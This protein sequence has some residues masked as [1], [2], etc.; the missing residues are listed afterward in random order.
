[1]AISVQA[2]TKKLNLE[3]IDLSKLDETRGLYFGNKILTQAKTVELIGCIFYRCIVVGGGFEQPNSTFIDCTPVAEI[4]IKV[5]CEVHKHNLAFLGRLDLSDEDLQGANLQSVYLKG[6]NLIDAD[7][8]G[9]NL[10]GAQLKNLA[11]MGAKLQGANLEGANLQYANLQGAKLQGANLQGANLQDANLQVTYLQGANLEKA[12]IQRAILQRAN[13]ENSN[14]Q[15]ANLKRTVL[16]NANLNGANLNG[17]NLLGAEIDDVRGLDTAIFSKTIVDGWA[18]L[19]LP[20]NLA[21]NA[22]YIIKPNTNLQ[23]ADLKGVNL[24]GA[25]LQGANLQ[26]ANLQGAE[27]QGANLHLANLQGA[28]LQE[29]KL[30][31]AEL[32]GANL[33]GADL[34]GADLDGARYNKFTKGLTE[35][36]KVVMIETSE[37]DSEDDFD[38]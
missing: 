12:D 18:E 17:A 34:E 33:E 16:H 15:G 10:Q 36:Q 32:Q 1:M 5:L 31:L 13:L 23:G 6:A 3:T 37:D 11:L 7:L 27:L 20:K 14:L 22:V 38:Y 29:S 26:F 21:P 9:A 24:N 19:C 35:R 30:L 2:L 28:E 4:T 8:R 25:K